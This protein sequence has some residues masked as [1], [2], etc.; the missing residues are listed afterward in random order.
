MEKQGWKNKDRKTRM[1][2]QGWKNKDSKTRIVKQEQK[3]KD[4][5]QGQKTRIEKQGQKNR[6]QIAFTVS[7][8]IHEFIWIH[9]S[10]EYWFVFNI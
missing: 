3:N 8:I 6:R 10:E 4:R 7:L 9:Y 5:K 2:K 1:E